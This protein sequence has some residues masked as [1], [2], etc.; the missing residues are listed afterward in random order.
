MW[1]ATWDSTFACAGLWWT[2]MVQKIPKLPKMYG[3]IFLPNFKQLK[4]R[5]IAKPNIWNLPTSSFTNLTLQW[6]CILLIKLCI[7]PPRPPCCSRSGG[8][9]ES[10]R[11]WSGCQPSCPCCSCLVRAAA[12]LTSPSASSR[13]LLSSWA[14]FGRLGQEKRPI[15]GSVQLS[16]GSLLR[17]LHDGGSHTRTR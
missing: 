10:G 3:K 9:A 6:L 11:R 17:Q 14:S 16:T 1:V 13:S 4:V 2:E 5:D 8:G 15:L 12:S 7:S